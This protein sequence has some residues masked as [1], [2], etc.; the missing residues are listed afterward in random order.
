MNEEKRKKLEYAHRFAVEHLRDE[1]RGFWAKVA[2]LLT[3]NSLLVAGFA[4]IMA[5]TNADM[6]LLTIAASG[7]A[8]QSMWFWFT[9]QSY[10]HFL[11]LGK[12][13][14]KTEKEIKLWRHFTKNRNTYMWIFKE[15]VASALAILLFASIFIAI[16]VEALL[17]VKTPPNDDLLILKITAYAVGISFAISA[18]LFIR[19][20]ILRIL[21]KKRE[22]PQNQGTA[23]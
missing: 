23:S 2:A 1:S 3:V 14:E 20:K 9:I 7:M 10:A 6:L 5:S 21:E 12:L 4:L 19:I 18:I 15:N 13:I 8:I 16:W 22:V 17:L 11:A